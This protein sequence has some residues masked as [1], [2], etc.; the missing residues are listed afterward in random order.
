MPF[1]AQDVAA[2][3]ARLATYKTEALS[4]KDVAEILGVSPST[5]SVYTA[6]GIIP[7]IPLGGSS[8]NVYS[9]NAIERIIDTQ[10][11]TLPT[12]RRD[13]TPTEKISPNAVQIT[14]DDLDH[15]ANLIADKISDRIA[16]VVLS[17]I[18]DDQ[19]N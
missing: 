3:K 16:D 12:P 8:A 10:R 13:K 9:P 14:G 2:A 7:K 1:T 19:R 15:L 4:M 18:T 17:K 6:R 11:H 5:V